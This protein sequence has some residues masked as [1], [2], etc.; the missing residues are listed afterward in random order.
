MRRQTG[1]YN[2]WKYLW[3]EGKTRQEHSWQ[4]FIMA[5]KGVSMW[6]NMRPQNVEGHLASKAL[7]DTVTRYFEKISL[8]SQITLKY[9]QQILSNELQLYLFQVSISL[10][11]NRYIFLGK[12]IASVIHKR[13]IQ[14][15]A[16][17]PDLKFYV[18]D[19]AYI[20]VNL[21]DLC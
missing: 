9:F 11:I 1:I 20:I 12:L 2:N 5:F 8:C 4:P 6:I 16:L 10:Y 14:P 19:P 3:R 18:I 21:S 17:F 13:Y 15:N 7:D